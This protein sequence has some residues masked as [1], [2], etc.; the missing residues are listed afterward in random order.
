M[1]RFN[2]LVALGAV[3]A[4]SVSIASATPIIGS[5]GV[6]N[7]KDVVTFTNT[8]VMFNPKT[9]TVSSA[10]GDFAGFNGD[11]IKLSNIPN[12]NNVSG[13]ELLSI[14]KVPGLTFT[15]SDATVVDYT[16][17][18]FLYVRG[19]GVFH[20]GGYDDTM[21]TFQLS[22]SESSDG[23]TSSTSF[24][25]TSAAAAAVTPEPNSLVLLGTGLVGAAGMLFMR[26]RTANNLL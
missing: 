26:R 15:L 2:K 4:A 20:E 22:I 14:A 6:G 8:S 3:V 13:I 11:T 25:I 21:G 18:D 19:D 24:E 17:N 23:T 1:N 9:G 7:P 16:A 12:L 10:T 5:I